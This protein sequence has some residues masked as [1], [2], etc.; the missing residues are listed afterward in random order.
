MAIFCAAIPVGSALGYVI[1]GLIGAHF[2]WRWAFYLVT[3]P[4]LLLGL[5]CFWQTDPR[6][7]SRHIVQASSRRRLADYLNLF[8]TRSYLINCVA[9]TLMTFAAGGLGFGCLPIYVIEIKV[10]PW[11]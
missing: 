7:V 11:A 4:G 3:P 10:Q 8:R 6:V 5:L 9:Q 1:G 2:G